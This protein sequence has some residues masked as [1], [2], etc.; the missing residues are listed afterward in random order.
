MSWKSFRTTPTERS[1]AAD[2]PLRPLA[3]SGYEAPRPV[4]NSRVAEIIA[5]VT[6]APRVGRNDSFFDVG[7]NSL[8]ATR[9]ASRLEDESG[10]RVPVRLLFDSVDI[11]DLARRLAEQP[12]ISDGP[13]LVRGSDELTG[14]ILLARRNAASGTRFRRVP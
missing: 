12:P 7:G 11:A 14:P 13:V 9:V 5:D 4:S 8:S 6:G 1:T 2:C 3:R 10:R